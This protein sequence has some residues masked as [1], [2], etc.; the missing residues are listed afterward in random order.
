MSNSHG[1][2]V[3]YELMTTDRGAAKAFY[4]NVVG[5]GTQDAPMPGMIYTMFTNGD[6]PV[7]GLMDQPEEARKMG[8]PPSWLGYVAVNDVDASTEQAKRLGAHVH[9]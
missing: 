8:A 5:W 7:G 2:F 3:W 9:V 1:R 4:S 6:V